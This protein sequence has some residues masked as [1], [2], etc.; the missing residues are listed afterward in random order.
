MAKYKRRIYCQ[1]CDY[2]CYDPDDM[3]S[4]I[5]SKHDEMIPSDMSPWQFFYYL[6][7]G[8]K[9][10]S[11][12]ICHNPTKWNEKT[13]KYNRFCDNPKCKEKYK[14]TFNKRMIGK[15]GKTTLLNDPDHQRKMLANRKISGKYLWR[16]NVHVSTYTGSFEKS[17]LE[18]LDTVLEFDPEDV[19]SPSPHTYYYEYEGTKHF[20][21]PD[22]FIPSLSLEVEIKDDIKGPNP[23][24]HPKI[25]AV[26][27]EKE[28][29]KDEV[30]KSNS[31]VF[32]YIKILDMHN[33]KLLTYLEEAKYREI[34]GIKGNIVML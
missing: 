27:K 16:D 30:M 11:C 1:F 2:F 12:V 14:Q 22:F 25:V 26:D 18:F 5:E 24:T 3:V 20:Y 33:E 29:L 23:N 17:F 10:G 19:M 6:K 32:N 8:K 31:N 15:Y 13:H 28:K 21:I 7:T 9:N 4:H 34:N